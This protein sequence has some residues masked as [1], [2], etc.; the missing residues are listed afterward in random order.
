MK[1]TK[2]E[3]AHEQ[4]TL[5]ERQTNN[6]KNARQLLQLARRSAECLSERRRD[7]ATNTRPTR[8]NANEKFYGD[9]LNYSARRG[10]NEVGPRAVVPLMT[11][12]TFLISMQ[13]S[14]F[15]L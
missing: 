5:I 2:V 3:V 14:Q 4:L 11:F 7:A 6:R 10:G 9:T 8:W 13:S 1:A 15:V 12:S